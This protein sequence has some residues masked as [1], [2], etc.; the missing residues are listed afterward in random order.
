MTLPES[1][2]DVQDMTDEKGAVTPD[3][4]ALSHEKL[5]QEVG[6]GVAE[7]IED[8]TAPVDNLVTGAIGELANLNDK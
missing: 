1:P 5:V 7:L 3:T 8:F 4:L 6:P 2:T